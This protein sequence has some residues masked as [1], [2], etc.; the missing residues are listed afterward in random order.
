MKRSLVFGLFFIAVSALIAMIGVQAD[1][2]PKASGTAAPSPAPSALPTATPEPPDKAIPRLLA[3]LKANPNDRDSLG[4]LAEQYLSIGRPDLALP[5]TQK[6]LALGSRTAQT[7]YFDGFANEQLG[8]TPQAVSDYEQAANLDPTNIGVLGALTQV[9]LKTNRIADAE[10]IAKRAVTFNKTDRR[11]FINYGLVLAS[12]NKFDDG[13]AQLET[14]F[15][16]DP[17]DVTPLLQIAQTYVSQNAYPN[18]LAAIQRAVTADPKNPQTY[19]LKGDI[20][21]KQHDVVNAL[22]AYEQAVQ[23]ASD[24]DQRAGIIGREA[25]FLASEKRNPEAQATFQRAIDRYPT[26]LTTHLTYG[27]YW[28]SQNQIAK[29][30]AEWTA[31][32]GP[33]KDNPSALIRLGTYNLRSGHPGQAVDYLKT[34]TQAAPDQASF[35]LLGQAYTFNH[36]Y[37]R[38]KDACRQSY[39]LQPNPA[40]LGCIAGADFE[41]KN[42]KESAAIFDVLDS[43]VR[44]YLDQ[45]G[46]LLFIAGKVYERTNQK[47][48]AVTEYKRLLALV[49]PGTPAYKQVQQTIKDLSKGTSKKQKA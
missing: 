41:L 5:L 6:L 42:F 26:V 40:A 20:L 38:A 48:K 45:N 23:Y 9:Y 11:A 19:L 10:R 35:N 16:M 36:D 22:A 30:V 1:A 43:R 21:A 34:L 47:G 39:Q 37:G 33:N 14:A 44:G 17:T 32:L 8:R 29:A 18:A 28:N 25:T 46:Q 13:R 27:D 31:A 24:D 2:R 4:Q 7:Y 15:K 49:R 3:N 12:E